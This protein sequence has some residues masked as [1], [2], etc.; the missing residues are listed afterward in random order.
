M[1]RFLSLFIVLFT[2]SFAQADQLTLV[3]G[4]GTADAGKAAECKLIEPFGVDFDSNG[5]MYIVEL[6]GGRVLKVDAKGALSVFAG[7]AKQKGDAGDGGPAAKALFNGLH[8]LAI[9]P[10][11][12]I[13]LA[14][15]WNQ[16]VRKIDGKSG[17][18]STLAGTGKKGY[19][20]DGGPAVKAEFGGIYCV[21]LDPKAENLYLADLDNKRIRKIDLGS[22]MLTTVAGTGKAGVPE[23][24]ATAAEAPLVD[25]RAVAVDAKGNVYVLERGGHALRVVDPAGKIK[26]VAGT[27]KQGNAGDGGDARKALLNGPK[28]LCIDRDGNVLIADAE[29]NLVRKYLPGDGTI[30]RVAGTGKRGA[31]GVDGP[32]EKTE[33]ARPHGVFVHPSGTLYITDSYNNR[34]LKLEK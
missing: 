19:S 2:C 3:A 26:T 30:V 13:Y 10:N 20:G 12:D 5:N 18:V 9:A 25:P 27:G 22:G 6:S 34:I 23:D 15:T 14:D 8:N 7:A 31:G 32:P 33:L 4:G 16:K 29:N 24:G 28:H 17:Q 11:G 21:A 1:S